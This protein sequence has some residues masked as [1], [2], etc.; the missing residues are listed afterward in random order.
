MFIAR[1]NSY[2]TKFIN[3]ELLIRNFEIDIAWYLNEYLFVKYLLNIMKL[4][5]NHLKVMSSNEKFLDM[6]FRQQ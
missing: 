2:L 5:V 4:S 3:I 1:I 6:N